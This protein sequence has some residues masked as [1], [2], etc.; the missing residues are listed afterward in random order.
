MPVL[1]AAQNYLHL[2]V[3][4]IAILL[5]GFS[6]GLLAKKILQKV[7]REVEFNKIMALAGI[8]YNLERWLSSLAAYVIYVITVILFLDYLNIRRVALYSFIG[9]VIILIVLSLLVTLKDVIPNLQGWQKIRRWKTGRRVAVQNMAGKIERI[10]YLQTRI[11]TPR[12]DILY[13]PNALFRVGDR[14]NRD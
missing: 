7:L 4:A 6:A 10:G 12:G 13:V 5:I 11:K 1:E 3:V 9:A 14:I 8:N 2:L